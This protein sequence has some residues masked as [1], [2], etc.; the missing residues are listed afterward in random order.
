M[1]ATREHMLICIEAN[2]SHT[3]RW[4]V[5]HQLLCQRKLNAPLTG[6]RHG[7]TVFYP[8]AA[9]VTY[10]FPPMAFSKPSPTGIADQATPPVNKVGLT[11]PTVDSA[12]LPQRK[13]LH[14]SASLGMS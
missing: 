14:R 1:N 13:F 6:L 8:A 9:V 3:W 7:H 2:G 5:P 12:T 10:T 11:L 4:T